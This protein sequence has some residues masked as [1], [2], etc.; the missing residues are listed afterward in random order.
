VKPPDWTA[1]FD[2]IPEGHVFKL[3]KAIYGT[4]QAARRWHSKILE[5]MENNG[6]DIHETS[7]SISSSMDFLSMTSR[8]EGSHA[9][10]KALMHD[11]LE[12]YSKGFEITG[13]L[14][15]VRF[16]GL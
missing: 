1:G 9:T 6:Y 7:R 10:K 5:W 3:K 12:K 11:F 2:L 14:L 13:D 15:M 8:Q 4:K 16:I